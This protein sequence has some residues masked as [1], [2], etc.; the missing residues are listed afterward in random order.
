MQFTAWPVPPETRAAAEDFLIRCR[1]CWPIWI[2]SRDGG[3]QTADFADHLFAISERM[4]RRSQL[5][6]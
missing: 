1:K 6:S 4:S 2:T 5:M 3:R